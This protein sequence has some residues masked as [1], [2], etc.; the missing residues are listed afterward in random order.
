MKDKIN[1]KPVRE[2]TIT[3]NTEDVKGLCPDLTD[4]EAWEVLK[5]QR[6]NFDAET[7][8]NWD[9]LSWVIDELYPEKVNSPLNP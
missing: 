6:D 7:G 5:Y 8:V 2:I 9:S 4:D 1:L 3:W